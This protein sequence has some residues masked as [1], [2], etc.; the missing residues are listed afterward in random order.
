MFLPTLMQAEG[1]R[2][3]GAVRGALV[4]TVGPPASL[5]MG[6]ALLGER[7]GL[8]QLLGTASIIVGVLVIGLR[9]ASPKP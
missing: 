7:P 2:R 3:I 1:I 5:L 4:S 9:S 6:A 8:W